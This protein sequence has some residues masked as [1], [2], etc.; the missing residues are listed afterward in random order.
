M[1]ERTPLPMRGT[2]HKVKDLV[3]DPEPEPERGLGERDRNEAR[4]FR[5][6]REV[7]PAPAVAALNKGAVSASHRI[8]GRNIYSDREKVLFEKL[9][10]HPAKQLTSELDLKES[11]GV[12]YCNRSEIIRHV[13]DG[14]TPSNRVISELRND[15]EE[16]KRKSDE[17]EKEVKRIGRADR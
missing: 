3:T 5:G 6:D 7:A 15:L 13:K 1:K 11:Q 8:K 10:K 2:G 14:R 9:L 12:E 16:V 17:L 4:R